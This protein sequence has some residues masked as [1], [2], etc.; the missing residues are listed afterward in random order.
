MQD[1][2]DQVLSGISCPCGLLYIDHSKVYR[3]SLGCR[4][5]RRYHFDTTA[6]L[7]AFVRSLVET[8]DTAAL[9]RGRLLGA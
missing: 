2:R 4:C 8:D 7:D 9:F 5:G 1:P 3:G 6:A